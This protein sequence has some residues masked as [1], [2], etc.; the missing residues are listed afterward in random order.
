M[1]NCYQNCLRAILLTVMMWLCCRFKKKPR[2]GLQY[3]QEHGLLGPSPDDIAEF[4]H[5]DDR[6]D[7]VGVDRTR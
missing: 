1:D 7:K 3:L 6:L 2:K 5:M 4:F